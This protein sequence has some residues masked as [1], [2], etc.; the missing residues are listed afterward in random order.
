VGRGER[1]LPGIWRLRLPLE[2]PGVPHCNAW[3][4]QAGDGIVLVD[5][6][7]HD[8]TSMANLERALERTGH[9][10]RDVNLIDALVSAVNVTS[11]AVSP[12]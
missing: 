4:L 9:T 12:R 6:G 10:L 1:V 2:L 11:A 3:A 8:R 7:M 5:T